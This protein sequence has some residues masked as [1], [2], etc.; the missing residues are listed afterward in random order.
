MSLSLTDDDKKFLRL[1]QYYN[2]LE[3]TNTYHIL[4]KDTDSLR[5]DP[6]IGHNYI[7]QFINPIGKEHIKK[8]LCK[9][10]FV[11]VPKEAID[12]GNTR[13]VGYIQCNLARNTIVRGNVEAGYL[14]GFNLEELTELV[15]LTIPQI[16]TNAGIPTGG[17]AISKNA[18]GTNV[19]YISD[20]AGG[21][22][23][24]KDITDFSDNMA[25]IPNVS[26][27][28]YDFPV[29]QSKGVR[30][31]MFSNPYVLIDNPFGQRIKLD[32]KESNFQTNVDFGNGAGEEL[33][34]MLEVKLIPNFQENDRLNY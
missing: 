32:I 25:A 6:A 34:I 18:I 33:A 7:D 4:L 12:D 31:T 2:Y 16:I 19:G 22:I 20:G 15:D 26:R 24:I 5:Y 29:L 9:V 1:K 11:S 8:A 21:E 27:A 23:A 30:A 14:G 13:G 17:G 28:A 10:V 3:A